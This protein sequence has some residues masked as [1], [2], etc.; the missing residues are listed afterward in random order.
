MLKQMSI[1]AISL[2]A[3]PA[4]AEA[5]QSARVMVAQGA[6]MIAQAAPAPSAAQMN[7]SDRSGRIIVPPG[8]RA[9]R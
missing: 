1:V 3:L 7:K 5:Q 9:L 2:V 8:T 6:P 4:I